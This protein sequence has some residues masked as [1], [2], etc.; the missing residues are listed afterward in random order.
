[1]KGATYTV[2]QVSELSGASIRALHHYEELGLLCPKRRSNGYREYTGSDIERLQQ[3]LLYRECGMELSA[4]KQVL[5]GPDYD[6]HAALEQ[7][8]AVLHARK[9]EIDTLIQTVEKTIRSLEGGEVMTDE[10]R[11]EGLKHKAIE[12]NERTYGA[13]ARRRHGDAVI[14]AANEKLLDMDKGQWAAKD[15]LEAAIIE[16]LK[17]ALAE[18]DPFGA[19]A[20]KLAQ[21]HEQWI[22]LQW[23][24][25]AYSREAHQGLAHGYLADA[26]FTAYY[27]E[28][29][30]EG[31]TAFLVQALDAYLEP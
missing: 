3:I 21:M 14:D 1:M 16:Q 28:R 2:K 11:F 18:G 26:R 27:D 24:D 13:E 5:D 23:P 10:E 31:A 20:H 30:G 17:T 8:L 19:A 12:D 15:E 29:A 9:Q 4:V 22:R 6:R 7:H 25:G